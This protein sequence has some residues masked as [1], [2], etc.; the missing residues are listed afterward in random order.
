MLGSNL[1]A[2]TGNTVISLVIV[3][4]ALLFKSL[5]VETCRAGLLMSEEEKTHTHA[6]VARYAH[7]GYG[8]L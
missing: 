4:D 5:E 2:V 3:E 7:C 6:V 8:V 1:V